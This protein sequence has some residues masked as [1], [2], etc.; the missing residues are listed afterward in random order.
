MLCF[1]QSEYGCIYLASDTSFD[2]RAVTP[3]QDQG[4]FVFCNCGSGQAG[5]GQVVNSRFLLILAV[6]PCNVLFA[7]YNI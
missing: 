1:Q 4:E 5:K 6:K 7:T 2:V 3:R